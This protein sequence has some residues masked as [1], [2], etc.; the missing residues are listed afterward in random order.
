MKEIYVIEIS[1]WS[2]EKDM[3]ETETFKYAYNNQDEAIA[4][5]KEIEEN[6]DNFVDGEDVSCYISRVDL[7]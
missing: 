7:V 3:Y 1:Y 2:K 4:A 6:P 5:A